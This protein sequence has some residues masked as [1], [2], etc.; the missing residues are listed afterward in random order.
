[1]RTPRHIEHAMQL[2]SKLQDCNGNEIN[3]GAYV[4]RL[5]ES[6]Q[7]YKMYETQYFGCKR[8]KS[9]FNDGSSE[10][11][12]HFFGYA[13]SAG[14]VIIEEKKANPFKSVQI[15]GMYLL[16]GPQQ[17]MHAD[18]VAECFEK[19]VENFDK[20]NYIE[21]FW[22]PERHFFLACKDLLGEYSF[23]D[24]KHSKRVEDFPR[25]PFKNTAGITLGFYPW[26]LSINDLGKGWPMAI[27]WPTDSEKSYDAATVLNVMGNF[28][29]RSSDNDRYK[30]NMPIDSILV[31][32]HA[33]EMMKK[34]LKKKGI[35]D[36]FV[37]G[38][39]L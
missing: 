31:R 23:N 28:I 36:K 16:N 26:N 39:N 29:D 35:E 12:I 11:C 33:K 15:S 7:P 24:A 10:K 13:D 8:T 5:N 32:I 21:M 9:I 4:L 17:M 25:M 37:E 20:E 30:N 1:M 6:F 2:P 34:W 27:G 3:P 38:I 14:E 18:K 22:S 19:Y